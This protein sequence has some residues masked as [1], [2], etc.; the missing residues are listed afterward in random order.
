M[1][2][3]LFG[4]TYG[5]RLNTDAVI[6]FSGGQKTYSSFIYTGFIGGGSLQSQELNELQEQNQF[7]TTKTN[8]FIGNWLK[9]EQD[10]IDSPIFT[11][12]I[13]NK[14]S[15]INPDVQLD[16]EPSV[17][18]GYYLHNLTY[19]LKLPNLE[20]PVSYDVSEFLNENIL[21]EMINPFQ[22]NEWKS[23]LQDTFNPDNL[24]PFGSHRKRYYSNS[25]SIV[26][27]ARFHPN[28]PEY[29]V[30]ANSASLDSVRIIRK[31]TNEECDG[32]F[33]VKILGTPTPTWIGLTKSL[34]DEEQSS[35]NFDS[36]DFNEG[37]TAGFIIQ[38]IEND[39]VTRSADIKLE[40]NTSNGWPST[41]LTQIKIK[42]AATTPALPPPT[43]NITSLVSISN[44]DTGFSVDINTQSP[45]TF[46][47]SITTDADWITV[48][49]SEN[50]FEFTND[51]T[52][53]FNCQSQDEN[54]EQRTATINFSFSQNGI[55]IPGAEKTTEVVQSS[56]AT[57]LLFT[58]PRLAD[59]DIYGYSAVKSN[60][61]ASIDTSPNLNLPYVFYDAENQ[62][63]Y[64]NAN[65]L[66]NYRYGTAFHRVNSQP[67]QPN[68]VFQAGSLG[69]F[70]DWSY[71][72]ENA[73]ST[74][75]R[76][77]I[78]E[79]DTDELDSLSVGD[80]LYQFSTSIL[81]P[82]GELP[83]KKQATFAGEVMS[84]NDNGIELKILPI[85]S[86]S[87]PP[88]TGAVV[89]EFSPTIK[90]FY[91]QI[92]QLRNL[93]KQFP[94]YKTT[95][96]KIT[97]NNSIIKYKPE[98]GQ[99][100]QETQ[101]NIP[102]RDLINELYH[103]ATFMP[104]Q[105]EGNSTRYVI[106]P[107]D[108]G[109]NARK[110]PTGQ[111]VSFPLYSKYRYYDWIANEVRGSIKQTLISGF[112]GNFFINTAGKLRIPLGGYVQSDTE[113]RR[114]YEFA[115]RTTI[116]ASKD[117][118]LFQLK[119]KLISLNYSLDDPSI[120]FIRNTQGEIIDFA[121]FKLFFDDDIRLVSGDQTNDI[122]A[123]FIDSDGKL[124]ALLDR[125]NS[126]G[127][128]SYGEFLYY[129]GPDWFQTP[130]VL[131]DENGPVMNPPLDGFV[132][133]KTVG[134]S[135]AQDFDGSASICWLLHKSGKLY[136]AEVG[137]SIFTSIPG[138]AVSN[139]SQL[140]S[141]ADSNFYLLVDTNSPENIPNVTGAGLAAE[142]KLSEAD[143][144]SLLGVNPNG[145][146]DV[147]KYIKYCLN[148]IPK[149]NGTRCPVL[150]ITGTYV[151]HSSIF[152]CALP[153]DN[154]TIPPINGINQ[155]IQFVFPSLE[156]GTFYIALYKKINT[157][158]SN[159]DSSGQ[160][161]YTLNDDF[162]SELYDKLFKTKINNTV[163]YLPP[164]CYGFRS[165]GWSQFWI[166]LNNGLFAT[167]C[168][169]QISSSG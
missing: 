48:P 2:T 23:V 140:K 121:P 160:W 152:L 77:N 147:K 75:I 166:L 52:I 131:I 31:N 7:Q 92:G 32:N 11:K 65:S 127:T 116:A 60:Y 135:A 123:V 8:E 130:G 1:S 107:L 80:K 133:V 98:E 24:S 30:L 73:G 146:Y 66:D 44:E 34:G 99:L 26:C 38:W 93:N 148:L 103:R 68:L 67:Q 13:D 19:F 27:S 47:V 141:P 59:L 20:L 58:M 97:L 5:S 142:F 37:L 158:N 83:N 82:T 136:G 87:T 122:F 84:K 96:T 21:T 118:A 76:V 35:L 109:D 91:D 46:T 61:L 137:K 95:S 14:I 168:P 151:W 145:T 50:N 78:S 159:C 120:Q 126:I 100:L 39:G 71:W 154:P 86:N 161:T 45:G 104:P 153:P 163:V 72:T 139:A 4:S 124:H 150:D 88:T 12:Q 119:E 62:W 85:F 9:I 54:D 55:L 117:E 94:L 16:I 105:I 143:R 164:R 22:D 155:K 3:P 6:G 81:A 69:R 25:S 110:S 49:T 18:E 15:Y 36:N 114:W 51:Q 43:F 74:Y 102:G 112:F 79:L 144:E 70:S 106:S 157:W 90:Y 115:R 41:N 56:A 53:S 113:T 108:L 138:T 169:D 42:Q 101:N 63:E 125:F 10:P 132:K 17:P 64:S 89:E 111:Q 134:G 162:D 57:S 29:N 165:Y 156:I 129:L 40:S 28:I 167:N 128:P 33:T 149:V